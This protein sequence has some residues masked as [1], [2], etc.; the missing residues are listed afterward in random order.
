MTESET[1][2]QFTL[3]SLFVFTTLV[4]VSTA[5]ICSADQTTIR[6]VIESYFASRV[7]VVA[8]LGGLIGMIAN[9]IANAFVASVAATIV[10]DLCFLAFVFGFIYFTNRDFEV[11]FMDPAAILMALV[12]NHMLPICIIGGSAASCYKARTRG[13]IGG[14]SVA[15]GFFLLYLLS[16]VIRDFISG[17][18]SF[19]SGVTLLIVLCVFLLN[20]TL[21]TVTARFTTERL[22]PHVTK[23]TDHALHVDIA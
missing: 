12:W 1:T 15:F 19:P 11:E 13:I 9:R 22:A 4:C 17:T 20:I 21:T 23:P 18:N 16:Y 5:I 6:G 7:L 10:A 3:R 14:M 8:V 2:R